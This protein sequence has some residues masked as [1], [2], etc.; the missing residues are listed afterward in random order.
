MERIMQ[1]HFARIL[2]VAAA[3][4]AVVAH[5]RDDG[6]RFAQDRLDALVA[7]HAEAKRHIAPI[8]QDA[9]PASAAAERTDGAS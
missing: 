9:P 6:P 5:A 1:K 3:S 2:L 4:T 7:Q 8:K